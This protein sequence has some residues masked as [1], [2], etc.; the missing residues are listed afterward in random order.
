MT[1]NINSPTGD[2]DLPIL[3][4]EEYDD[5]H[6][7][8]R[9]LY[10]LH[11]SKADRKT[12]NLREAARKARVIKKKMERYNEAMM[13]GKVVH[14]PK[15]LQIGTIIKDI[16]CREDAQTHKSHAILIAESLISMAEKGNMMAIAE[17]LNRVDGKVAE[18]HTVESAPIT[19][20][21][22]P[23]EPQGVITPA[24][25]ERVSITIAPTIESTV[26]E[27]TKEITDGTN[28]QT[29]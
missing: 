3:P 29:D 19:L 18:K 11:L 25:E 24:L 6:L 7:K 20:L 27:I 2:K 4:P 5:I 22:Q 10:K 14:I 23:A 28:N 21:F 8:K 16:L 17:I 13:E 26:K 15:E 12:Q 1:Q 9:K